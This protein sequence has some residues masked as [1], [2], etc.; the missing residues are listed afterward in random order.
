MGDTVEIGEVRKL[1]D[2]AIL[3]TSLRGFTRAGMYGKQP[4]ENAPHMIHNKVPYIVDIDGHIHYATNYIIKQ[5]SKRKLGYA[6]Y[7]YVHTDKNKNS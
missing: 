5:L 6:M 7:T 4:C 1:Y 3:C 2:L